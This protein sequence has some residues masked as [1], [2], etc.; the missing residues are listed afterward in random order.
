MQ[1]H[2]TGGIGE[3][4]TLAREGVCKGLEFLNRAWLWKKCQKVD[5]NVDYSK[6]SSKK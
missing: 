5:G 2:F 4:A 3:N 1:L 6:P